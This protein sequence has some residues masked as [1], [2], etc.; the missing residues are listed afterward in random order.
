MLHREANQI[1]EI[2]GLNIRKIGFISVNGFEE[3]EEGYAKL[4]HDAGFPDFYK[5]YLRAD[6]ENPELRDEILD[7]FIDKIFVDDDGKL[8]FVIKRYGKDGTELVEMSA[9][10]LIE[11]QG[12][13][14]FDNFIL[15][16][17][18]TLEADASRV[19]FCL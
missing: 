19:F 14:V 10:E 13:T 9:E 15:C 12:F 16:S 4:V 2:P 5:K 7:Y 11:N 1:R 3:K 18:T 17:T 8:S 6:L